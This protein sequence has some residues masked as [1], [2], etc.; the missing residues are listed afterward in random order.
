[1]RLTLTRRQAERWVREAR[2]GNKD[3]GIADARNGDDRRLD[4]E[5]VLKCVRD[6]RDETPE[7]IAAGVFALLDE[8]TGDVPRRDDLTLLVLKS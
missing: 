7:Q 1:M 3:D 6:H 8:Y 4:E 2:R 5:P